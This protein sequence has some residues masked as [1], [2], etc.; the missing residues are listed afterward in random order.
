[1]IYNIFMSFWFTKYG[2]KK[3][4]SKTVFGRIGKLRS[5][6]ETGLISFKGSPF[7]AYKDVSVKMGGKWVG[8]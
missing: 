8:Y 1:M 2:G 4:N 3:K 7:S 6:T 5:R